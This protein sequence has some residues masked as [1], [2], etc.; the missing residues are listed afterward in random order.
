MNYYSK[1]SRHRWNIINDSKWQAVSLL[2]LVLLRSLD[3]A[4]ADSH[5]NLVWKDSMLYSYD[6]VVGLITCKFLTLI[7]YLKKSFPL[8]CARQVHFTCFQGQ[9]FPFFF[10]FNQSL[11]NISLPLNVKRSWNLVPRGS[12]YLWVSSPSLWLIFRLPV[13]LLYMIALPLYLF[14]FQSPV[15]YSLTFYLGYYNSL[16]SF[17]SSYL[18]SPSY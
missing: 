15:R 10:F 5:W 3:R 6:K 4:L 16:T 1:L 7:V 12:Y 17:H 8:F 18:W 13:F 14:C 2:H 11:L 9:F